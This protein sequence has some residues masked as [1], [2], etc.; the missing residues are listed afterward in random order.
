MLQ[1]GLHYNLQQ[2]N[3]YKK[4]LTFATLWVFNTNRVCHVWYNF[5]P[6]YTCQTTVI[7]RTLKHRSLKI[8]I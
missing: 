5:P 4:R 8:N 3:P 6:G 2:K 7:F 1:V